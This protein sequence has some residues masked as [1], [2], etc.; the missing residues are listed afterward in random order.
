[1]A[2]TCGGPCCAAA[3][4]VFFGRRSLPPSLS[5][6]LSRVRSLYLSVEQWVPLPLLLDFGRRSLSR[7]LSHSLTPSLYIYIERERERELFKEF[8]DFFEVIT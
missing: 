1:M 7:S 8:K 3:F 4:T 5:I 2:P 6:C